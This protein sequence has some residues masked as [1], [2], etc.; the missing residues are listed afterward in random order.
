MSVF[1]SMVRPTEIHKLPI[2]LYVSNS[3]NYISR[4]NSS[5]ICIM[6]IWTMKQWYHVR[7][8]NWSN[9]ITYH[10]HHIERF[11]VHP[12]IS[13][14]ETKPCTFLHRIK[15]IGID[16]KQHWPHGL[17]HI[18]LACLHFY[19][20]WFLIKM[21]CTNLLHLESTIM[22]HIIPVPVFSS[23][24]AASSPKMFVRLQI[25]W[26]GVHDD[27]P[28]V[29]WLVKLHDDSYNRCIQLYCFYIIY[30]SE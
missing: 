18:L 8:Q 14:S 21:I 4:N 6:I 24:Y 16:T 23:L 1:N 20:H 11:L 2:K 28:A 30:T 19:Y 12:Y 13:V 22:Y 27:S 26:Q 7:K 5:M 17:Q 10:I 15:C 3:C 29:Y 9:A 25:H